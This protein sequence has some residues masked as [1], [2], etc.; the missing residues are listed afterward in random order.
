MHFA[1]NLFAAFQ[2]LFRSRLH[3]RRYRIDVFDCGEHFFTARLLFAHGF[4]ET[5]AHGFYFFR[6]RKNDIEFFF[7]DFGRSGKHTDF[8]AERLQR[9]RYPFALHRRIFRKLSDFTGDDGKALS[10]FPCVSRFDCGVH[11]KQVRLACDMLDN[12]RRFHKRSRF[13]GDTL[14]N[15]A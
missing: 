6:Q 7:D 10:G 11:R 14:R 5:A 12:A 13:F 1:G 2:H 8:V 4:G 3:F 15:T 9:R